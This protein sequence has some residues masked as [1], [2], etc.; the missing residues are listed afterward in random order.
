MKRVVIVGVGFGGL[1]AAMAL[2]GKG[3]EVVLLDRQNYHLFQPLLYQVATASLEQES[4]AY[5]IR[6]MVRRWEGVNFRLA[7]VCGVD[8]ENRRLSIPGDFIEY[9]YLVLAAGSITN[10]FGMESVERNAY[11]LKKLDHAVDLRNQVL[12]SFERAARE[13]D[14]AR[15]RALLTFVI[16]GGGPTGVEFA[17]ALA[18]LDRF[19]LTKDYPELQ[20]IAPRVILVEAMDRLLA[21]FPAELQ[22]YTLEKLK[23]MGVEVMLNTRVSGAEPE[24]VFLHDG[25]VIPAHTL[26]W[27]AGVRVAPLADSIPVPK[28]SAG[29]IP[30]EPDLSLAGH[31][32]VFVV[33]D[34]AYLE[35]DGKPLPMV[36]SVAMQEGDYAGKAI[37]ARYLDKQFPPF[38]FHDKGSMATIGRS[39]AVAT[40][41]GKN[42]SG[43]LA[44]LVWLGLHLYYLIGFRNRLL[45]L[46]NWSYYY[47]LYERQIRL[48][49]REG[50][51]GSCE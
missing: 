20:A 50:E 23:R 1:R 32:E 38:R 47:I 43:F 6:A 35:Q 14:P 9:D 3:M 4:I 39:A 15:R 36:A 25:T 2:A 40:A 49:T 45:V 13:S 37:L 28:K 46:L 48:I 51:G 30:V 31:P 44:W 17:G 24:R 21:A 34:L 16:V 8:L 7:E 33:G 27:S 5:P 12:G 26:F 41:Y 19:V 29:R 10:F 22:E 42:Y 11:D 18:E